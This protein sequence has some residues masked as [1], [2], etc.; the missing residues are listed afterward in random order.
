MQWSGTRQLSLCS[1][2]LQSGGSCLV[3]LLIVYL[4]LWLFQT[5]P[6]LLQTH[7]T[8]TLTASAL[9]L[10]WLVIRRIKQWIWEVKCLYK[11]SV[12]I[13]MSINKLSWE[14]LHCH[15]ASLLFMV[16]S[17]AKVK[18]EGGADRNVMVHSWAPHK[19]HWFN[20]H[21]WNDLFQS[22]YSDHWMWMALFTEG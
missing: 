11:L 14:L 8:F 2:R 18:T 4:C 1:K 13:S 21:E 22:K 12:S 17:G 20:R 7:D 9:R 5:L 16:H 19:E 6:G 10:N 15:A 3:I